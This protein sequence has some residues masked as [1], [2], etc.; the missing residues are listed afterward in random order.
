ME[1]KFL[2]GDIGGQL[3][4][5]EKVLEQVGEEDAIQVG[6]MI[7][8]HRMWRENNTILVDYM[9]KLPHW[10]FI[11]G[12]HESSAL[13]GPKT[14]G[15]NISDSIDD[16][17]LATLE[18]LWKTIGL[19]AVDLDGVL[20]TH[21]GLTYDYW[22]E[23]G[24]PETSKKAAELINRDMGKPFKKWDRAGVL[25]GGEESPKTSWP[26]L[27]F[28]LLPSWSGKEM[29]F[30]QITGHAS[31]YKAFDEKF[32]V[33]TSEKTIK[34]TTVIKEFGF[35]RVAVGGKRLLSVDWTLGDV[36]RTQSIPRVARVSEAL[37]VLFS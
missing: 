34:N 19:L 11:F 21:G 2:I 3:L 26:H 16:D 33:N 24:M 25:V 13:G 29:P 18:E 28:E 15:K 22:V 23:L 14:A 35:S 10:D 32:W 8:L 30:H 4:V 9:E 17:T 20:L 12:N 7:R 36:V 31:P 6:D 5:F 37:E 27:E 1:E